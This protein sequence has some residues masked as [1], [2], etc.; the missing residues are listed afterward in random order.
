MNLYHKS[1]VSALSF[2]LF[3]SVSNSKAQ[4]TSQYTQYIFNYFGINPAAGGSTKCL[5][6]D[7]SYG[8]CNGV[9]PSIGELVDA[10]ERANVQSNLTDT[11]PKAKILNFYLHDFYSDSGFVK[12]TPQMSQNAN[13][14]GD[15]PYNSADLRYKDWSVIYLP[16]NTEDEKWIIK[17]PFDSQNRICITA[18]CGMDYGSD[19]GYNVTVSCYSSCTISGCCKLFDDWWKKN[20]ISTSTTHG[21][22]GLF[23][24]N[25]LKCQK[26]TS[27]KKE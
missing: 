24:L 2:L 12:F 23:D 17:G 6:T 9:L 22:A 25:C 11:L 8:Q 16:N 7:G 5:M 10:Y 15:I 27:D 26:N 4:Q 3:L 19:G 21:H 18:H 20:N 13:A 14:D 1:L